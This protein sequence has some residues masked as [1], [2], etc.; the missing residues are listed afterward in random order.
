ML[1][2]LPWLAM[3][4]AAAA[5]K[6]AKEASNPLQLAATDTDMVWLQGDGAYK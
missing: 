4:L 1:R 6:E 5:A 3:L 2:L